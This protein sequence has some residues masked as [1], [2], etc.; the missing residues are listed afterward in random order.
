MKG[1]F[2][3]WFDDR[4][5][6]THARVVNFNGYNFAFTLAGSCAGVTLASLLVNAVASNS[7]TKI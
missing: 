4:L 6:D 5:E 2:P 3:A 7:E 1:L